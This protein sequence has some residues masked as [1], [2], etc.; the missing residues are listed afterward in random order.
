M[1]Q[2]NNQL[3]VLYDVG[4]VTFSDTMGIPQQFKTLVI[5]A[6][7]D[8]ILQKYFKQL[9][10][11]L[12]QGGRILIAINSVEGDLNQAMGNNIFTGLSDWLRDKGIEV[13]DKFIVDAS[14]SDV[15]VRQQTGMFV[16]N[17]PVK[18]PYLPVITNFVKHP[19]T[20]GLES[21]V[22]PFASSI[23][24]MP[25]DTT[26]L[27]YPLAM[28]SEKSGLQSPPIRFDVM[29]KWG[30]GDFISS[31]LPIAVVVE[32]KIAGNAETKMIVFGDGDFVIN[33]EGQQAQQLQGDNVSFMSNAIDWLSDDTGLIELRTKGVTARPLDASL[34]DGTKTLLKYL[35]FLLPL[36][37][38]M[39]YGVYRFQSRRK[40]RNKLMN[41]SYVQE[42]K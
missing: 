22:L 30:P 13:E 16:M 40:L 32:G 3:S 38:I 25:K 27:M 41:I 39:I 37:L 36:I 17:T 12:E 8:T 28:T 15:M 10:D 7:K 34:E 14:C 1:Q 35:N 19:I 18:F 6:P 42:S 5:V 4:T 20:E 24:L 23:N 33:G 11:Y 21:V 26:V 9:D 2:L 31:S 29:K